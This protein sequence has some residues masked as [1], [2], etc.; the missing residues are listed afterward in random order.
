M[1]SL[2]AQSRPIVNAYLVRERDRRLLLELGALMGIVV[3]VAVGLAGNV[4]A[5]SEL[6]GT[7]Y[8]I[9]RL[10]RELHGLTEQERQLQLEV[11]F[12]SGPHTVETR[13]TEELG[14]R[15]W[16]LDQLIFAEDVQ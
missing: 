10:E 7:G 16:S 3:L 2:Y 15:A 9:D 6:V 1:Q 4:W 5:R 12:L 14:M 13:A 8:R 11:S